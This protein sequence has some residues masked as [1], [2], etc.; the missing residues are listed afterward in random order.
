MHTYIHTYSRLRSDAHKFATNDLI[1]QFGNIQIGDGIKGL[2]ELRFLPIIFFPF[3][4]TKK[5]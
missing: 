1:M 2:K 5:K 3:Q 4:P